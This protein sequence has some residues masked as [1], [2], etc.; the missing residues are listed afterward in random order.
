M[1]I[2][3]VVFIGFCLVPFFALAQD[4]QVFKCTL[5]DNIRRVEVVA[6]E[7]GQSVP[8]EVR[9]AKETEAA[10][11]EQVLWRATNEA[12]YC[13]ARAEEFLDKLESWGWQCDTANSKDNED[14]QE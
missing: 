6:L 5:N 9:Y 1:I 11:A 10:G 8:C 7:P 3:S 4:G 13:E 12:G 14:N 2:R